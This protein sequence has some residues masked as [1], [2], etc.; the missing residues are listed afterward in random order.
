LK[1][2]L[3]LKEYG[4]RGTVYVIEPDANARAW[5][6]PRYKQLLPLARIVEIRVSLS[7][8]VH[9]L[10]VETDAI[11]MNH[12]IDDLVLSAAIPAEQQK[13]IF[14]GMYQ[15]AP[16]H[17][18]VQ[19]IWNNLANN[20]ETFKTAAQRVIG[21]V[22]SLIRHSRPRLLGMS[23]YRSW[24]QEKNDLS[25][26]DE[27]TAPILRWLSDQLSD[28][29]ASPTRELRQIQGDPRW[30]LLQNARGRSDN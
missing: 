7:A 5:I 1:V 16:Y 21:D 17:P 25:F 19:R 24:S 30:L 26:V 12:V 9:E 13:T 2:G 8:A 22:C 11:L 28:E 23:Q 15:N 20:A 3:G 29:R 10:P 14:G 6:I 4:F 18:D 27:L